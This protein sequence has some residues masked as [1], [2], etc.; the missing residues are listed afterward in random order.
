MF[1]TAVHVY[2]Q[3]PLRHTRGKTPLENLTG[4]KPDIAYLKDTD[5]FTKDIGQIWEEPNRDAPENLDN[6]RNP[7]IDDLLPK[8]QTRHP[9]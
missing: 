4:K 1:K 2:N 8:K 7:N 6:Y 3:T 5:T 9:D